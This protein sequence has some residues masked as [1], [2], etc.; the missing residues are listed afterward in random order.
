MFFHESQGHYIN[1]SIP[2]G[3]EP[4]HSNQFYIDNLRLTNPHEFDCLNLDLPEPMMQ[5]TETLGVL[6]S[7]FRKEMEKAD[8]L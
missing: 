2:I 3:Y 1:R 8:R 7:L 6:T 5:S 4:K